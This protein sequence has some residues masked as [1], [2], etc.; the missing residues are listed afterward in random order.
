MAHLSFGGMVSL[1]IAAM[2][3]NSPHPE[4]ANLPDIGVARKILSSEYQLYACGKIFLRALISTKFSYF[5]MD[6][7]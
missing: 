2:L 7:K 4:M 5:W 6:T 1:G 3:V